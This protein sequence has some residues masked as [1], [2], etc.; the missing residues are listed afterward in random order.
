[1]LLFFEKGTRGGISAVT[2]RSAKANNKYLEEFNPGE[3]SKFLVYLDANALYSWA[4]TQP[5]PVGDF[6]WMIE[7]EL[8]NWMERNS[9]NETF[10]RQAHLRGNGNSRSFQNTDVRLSLY[11]KKKWEKIELC[12]TDADSFFYEIETEDVFKNTAEDVEEK[13]DTSDFEKEPFP[14]FPVG[15][16]KKKVGSFQG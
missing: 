13:F 3:R 9:E 8:E 4:M 10:I 16:N 12:F 7:E 6:S 15:K 11:A 1:M 5:L 14:G 2:K